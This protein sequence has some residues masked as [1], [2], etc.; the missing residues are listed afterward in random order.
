MRHLCGVKFEITIV[1]KLIYDAKKPNNSRRP[2]RRSKCRPVKRG[3]SA[4]GWYTQPI[5]YACR[6]NTTACGA[7]TPMLC[8]VGHKS[9][10]GHLRGPRF[11]PRSH[12]Y[13]LHGPDGG[14]NTSC[15]LNVFFF[16][17]FEPH[18][19]AAQNLPA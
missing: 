15:F 5:R 6:R 19:S 2:C 16:L 7:W 8:F 10:V 17:H 18:R 12:E 3:R 11:S 4:V 14:N 1:G 9:S 13:V